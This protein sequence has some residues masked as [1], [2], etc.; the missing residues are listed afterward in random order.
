MKLETNRHWAIV[1][2]TGSGKTTFSIALMRLVLMQSNGTLPIYILDSK[3]QGDFRVFYPIAFRH[4]GNTIP[5]SRWWM[6]EKPIQIWQPESDDLLLYDGWMRQLYNQRQPSLIYFDEISSITSVSGKP[7]RYYN[8]LQ[9]QGRGLGIGVISVTQSPSYIPATLLRQA[10]YFCRFTLN[11]DYDI[12]KL[13]KV[14]GKAILTP[15][16]DEHGFWFRDA[17]KP[18]AYSPPLYFRDYQ[19]FFR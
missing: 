1:G 10:T 4:Y 17:R 2:F 12:T 7:P 3:Q 13:A 11:D 8:I 18:V 14:M 6:P 5:P 9:Q 15:P 16:P 19:D